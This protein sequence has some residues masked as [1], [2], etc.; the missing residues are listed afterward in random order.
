MRA[1]AIGNVE[2]DGLV[3]ALD[4]QPTCLDLPTFFSSHI[5]GSN[6]LQRSCEIHGQHRVAKAEVHERIPVSKQCRR[7]L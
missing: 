1:E 2:G 5:P 4:T 6:L 3:A 7:G